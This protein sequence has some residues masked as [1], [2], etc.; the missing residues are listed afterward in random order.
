[1]QVKCISIGSSSSTK[2]FADAGLAK[3]KSI[4]TPGTENDD[5]LK[6]V[7]GRIKLNFAKLDK[8]RSIAKAKGHE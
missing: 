6:V 4:V 5:S 7:E 1:M 3:A 2:K 8:N